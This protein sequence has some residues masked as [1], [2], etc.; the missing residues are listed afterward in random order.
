MPGEDEGDDGGGRL[1]VGRVARRIRNI[2]RNR[3]RGRGAGGAGRR[4]LRR[5]G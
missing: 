5:R 2:L 3:R 1:R 4:R